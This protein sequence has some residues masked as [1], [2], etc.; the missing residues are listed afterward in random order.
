[1]N[2]TNSTDSITRLIVEE[3]EKEGNL[4]VGFARLNEEKQSFDPEI[5]NSSANLPFAIS[6]ALPLNRQV[7]QTI[8]DHPTV[9]YKQHYQQANYLLDRASLRIAQFLEKEGYRSLPIP[10]SIY[11]SREDQRAHLN[12]R[13][14]AFQAGIGWWGKCN[15]IVHPRFGAG[16]R[17]ATVL[18]DLPFD[19]ATLKGPTTSDGCGECRACSD[20]CPAHAIGKDIS[21]FNRSACFAQIREFERKVIG[22]GI[23]GI[24]VR[25][26]REARQKKVEDK[27]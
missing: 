18:T 15:L 11:T 16:I 9:I 8:T 4:L 20:A 12:H 24:C 2:S 23:C 6:L 26:C 10:A 13:E 5:S 7:L 27:G 19:S 3:A 14:I 22:V 25:A 1:M 17:L 21:E